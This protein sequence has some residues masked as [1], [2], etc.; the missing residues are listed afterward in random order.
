MCSRLKKQLCIVDSK[1]S[2]VVGQGC[3]TIDVKTKD[4][5]V[6]K[7]EKVVK[8]TDSKKATVASASKK[9]TVLSASKKTTVASASKKS[10]KSSPK[11]APLPVPSSPWKHAHIGHDNFWYEI[12]YSPSNRAKCH[13]CSQNI[14]KGKLRIGRHQANPFGDSPMIK[15]FHADHAFEEFAKSRCNSALIK[16]AK[17]EGTPAI[18]DADKLRIYEKINQLGILWAK[19]CKT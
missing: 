16:W 6:V 11:N 8:V 15:Y 10:S 13:G 2:W 14:I 4:A 3:N 1:C 5:K 7:A 17:L 9:A 18:S 12:G 19:K